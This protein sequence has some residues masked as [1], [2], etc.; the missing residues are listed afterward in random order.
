MCVTKET[1]TNTAKPALVRTGF[2]VSKT[3]P[4]KRGHCSRC[5]SPETRD[6]SSR[7]IGRVIPIG[8]RPGI[9]QG[10]GSIAAWEPEPPLVG[11]SG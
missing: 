11:R 8:P 1:K 5:A 4:R 3:G 6:H 7:V 2:S 10:R 9:H